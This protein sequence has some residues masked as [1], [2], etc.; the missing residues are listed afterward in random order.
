MAV[1]LVGSSRTWPIDLRQQAVSTLTGHSLS[2]DTW[3]ITQRRRA[4]V[5]ERPSQRGE[6]GRVNRGEDTVGCAYAKA[7]RRQDVRAMPA[8]GILPNRRARV[9][10]VA[11]QSVSAKEGIH[12]VDQRRAAAEPRWPASRA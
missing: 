8:A 11:A 12:L 4:R 9:A 5:P 10:P 1:P 6:P 3:P 2:R 7:V